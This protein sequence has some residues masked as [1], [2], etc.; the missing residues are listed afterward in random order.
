MKRHVIVICFLAVCFWFPPGVNGAELRTWTPKSGKFTVKAELLSFDQEVVSLRRT[1]G[2]TIKVPLAKLSKEDQEYVTNQ[3]APNGVPD[4]SAIKKLMTPDQ[5]ALGGP[6]VNSVDM[7]LVPIP[8][9]EFM[10]GSPA[11]EPDR[12]DDETQHEVKITKPF[13]L[14]AHEVTQAQ[15]Q[16]VMGNNPSRSKGATKPVELVNWYAAVEFC[17]KLSAQEGVEYRLP[18]EAEW[19]YARRAGTTTAFSFGADESQLG[20]YAWYRANSGDTTHPVGEKLPNGWGL[21]D[22]HGNVFEWCQD[23]Y[24]AYESLRVVSDPTGSASG[25]GRVLRGGAFNYPPRL[26]RAAVRSDVYLPGFRIRNVG[27]RL[28]RTYNLSP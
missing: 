17:Q 19:E 24:G 10:M 14:G 20:K 1:N 7:V 2:K 6:V 16:Q 13:Y 27:F 15:Y 3:G 22:M 9:G 28:A 26:V 4:T 5:L 23:W 11:S 18:T 8:A 12:G 21:Y 25:E